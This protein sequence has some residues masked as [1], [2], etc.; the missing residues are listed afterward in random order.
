MKGL[1][2]MNI[3]DFIRQQRLAR[4]YSLEELSKDI[5][6]KASLSKF[7][8]GLMDISSDKLL[9]LLDRLNISMHEFY[10]VITNS[11]NKNQLD[12]LTEYSYARKD[13]NKYLLKK[14]VEKEINLYQSSNNIRHKHNA[15]IVKQRL[16]QKENLPFD[17]DSTDKIIYYLHSLNEWFYYEIMLFSN[18]LFFLPVNQVEIFS[19]DILEKSKKISRNKAFKQE[20]SFTI[21]N[22][23]NNF[24]S[25]ENVNSA[26]GTINLLENYLNGSTYYYEIAKLNFLK[27]ICLI[28]SNR[29]EEGI[30][31]AKKSIALMYDMHDYTNV[32]V[33]QD[34]MD[35]ILNSMS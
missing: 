23:V 7:E 3:G 16:L 26:L 32:R 2:I 21:I 28:K 12:F 15:I 34:Y 27:G 31:L 20:I 4:N 19:R 6:T 22:I 11:Q 29:K 25:N 17:S 13:N 8:R 9:K 18:S 10:I 14:L 24:I 33:H 30:E 1:N 35:E 5:M